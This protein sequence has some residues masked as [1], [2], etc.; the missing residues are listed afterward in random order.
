MNKVCALKE[1]FSSEKENSG[2][3]CGEQRVDDEAHVVFAQVVEVNF[4]G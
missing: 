1:E 3:G 4:V 2:F